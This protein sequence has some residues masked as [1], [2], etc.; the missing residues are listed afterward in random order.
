[1]GLRWLSIEKLLAGWA[2]SVDNKRII[3][4]EWIIEGAA[5]NHK[6]S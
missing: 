2:Y 1:M 4:M 3:T 5:F 6:V